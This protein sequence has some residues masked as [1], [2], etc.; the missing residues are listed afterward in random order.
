MLAAWI[1]LLSLFT[2]YAFARDKR[3]AVEGERRT[4]EATLLML[5]AAGGAPGAL[6]AQQLFRHKTRKEPFRSLLWSIAAAQAACGLW[7]YLAR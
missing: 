2:F 6:A 5:A 3:A 4:P 1:A 7:I